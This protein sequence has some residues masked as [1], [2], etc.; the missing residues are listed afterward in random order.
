MPGEDIDRVDIVSKLQAEVI[1][2]LEKLGWVRSEDI[3]C[4][5]THVIRCAYVHHTPERD[6]LVEEILG[7]LE[8]IRNSSYRPVWP[9]GL[10]RNGRFDQFGA[11]DRRVPALMEA[12]SGGGVRVKSLI[13]TAD[14]FGMSI[15]VNEA[16]EA[17]HRDGI[18]SATS[19]MTGGEAFADAVE[20]ARRLPNLGVGLHIHLVDSRPVLPPEQVPDLVGP[21]GNFSN[22]PESFG[23]NLFFLARD[24]PTGRSRDQRPVRAL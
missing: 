17:S 7:R 5:V 6:Q 4:A 11:D 18:L 20:R 13:V 21:D 8:R 1:A 15:P 14:D 22:N 24:A 10:C 12:G 3:V 23:F 2:A 19:L 16:I 9:M